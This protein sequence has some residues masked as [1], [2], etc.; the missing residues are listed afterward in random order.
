MFA[1]QSTVDL[2]QSTPNGKPMGQRPSHGPERAENLVI[3][4]ATCAP[5]RSL[6]PTPAHI[7]SPS[8]VLDTSAPSLVPPS[9][10]VLDLSL[11]KNDK[12]K[13]NSERK[14]DISSST[15]S[16]KLPKPFPSFPQIPAATGNGNVARAVPPP[17][18]M[19]SEG[20]PP[21]L[22]SLSPDSMMHPEMK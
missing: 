20:C 14:D 3:T 19:H 13:A 2:Q 16:M 6:P 5:S 1:V 9:N 8:S 4:P 10:E 18:F 7:S 15:P 11:K 17:P 22:Q 12:P 21:R